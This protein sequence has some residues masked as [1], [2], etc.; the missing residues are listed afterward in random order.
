MSVT[1]SD[2][3]TEAIAD[4]C[5]L[6]YR[7]TPIAFN[8]SEYSWIEIGCTDHSGNLLHWPTAHRKSGRK[9]VLFL[10]QMEIRTQRVYGFAIW[11]SEL[12]IQDLRQPENMN[13]EFL[14]YTNMKY[15][16]LTY[17]FL[18]TWFKFKSVA[19]AASHFYTEGRMKSSARHTFSQHNSIKRR[20]WW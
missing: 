1:I 17:N 4:T 5:R 11:A 14:T 2:L 6:P 15:E 10:L 7:P 13:C 9:K 16:F 8:P 19:S 12:Q 18:K 20:C 3:V